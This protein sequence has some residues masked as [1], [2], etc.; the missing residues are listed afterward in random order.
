MKRRL[1]ELH[2]AGLS[3]FILSPASPRSHTQIHPTPALLSDAGVAVASPPAVRPTTN[4]LPRGHSPVSYGAQ[5]LEDAPGGPSRAF[6]HGRFFS[7]RRMCGQALR[8]L[9]DDA[10][11]LSR[12]RLAFYNFPVVFYRQKS[13]SFITVHCKLR[14]ALRK[15]SDARSLAEAQF[16]LGLKRRRCFRRLLSALCSGSVCRGNFPRPAAIKEARGLEL[17]RDRVRARSAPDQPWHGLLAPIGATS[18]FFGLF[19]TVW[20]S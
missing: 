16:A 3:A 17:C 1:L 18:P 11:G 10:C 6:A 5:I 19:G 20:A 7:P 14:G 13:G 8:V 2:I 4:R 12:Y 15:I 9:E